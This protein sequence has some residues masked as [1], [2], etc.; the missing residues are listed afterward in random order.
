MLLIDGV[1]IVDR[2][3]RFEHLLAD[4]EALNA[5]LN[6]GLGDLAS[7]LP[8]HKMTPR[9]S[10]D[11]SWMACLNGESIKTINQLMS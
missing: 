4:L 6:L 11:P 9:K 3:I 2:V 8:T 10:R 1:P 7:R 5:T